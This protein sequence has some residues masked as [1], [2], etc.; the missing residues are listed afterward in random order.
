MTTKDEINLYV[1]GLGM[2]TARIEQE[3]LRL[4]SRRRPK[5]DEISMRLG[6]ISAMQCLMEAFE[7]V[8][9]EGKY[10]EDFARVKDIVTAQW[11]MAIEMRRYEMMTTA[12]D[13]YAD[14]I[15]DQVFYGIKTAKEFVHDLNIEDIS[16]VKETP[17][18]AAGGAPKPPSP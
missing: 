15:E 11:Y 10:P 7:S 1:A 17:K 14:A 9:E 5:H 8:L 6:F 18:K 12:L 16:V 13:N 2:E 4:M 3:T